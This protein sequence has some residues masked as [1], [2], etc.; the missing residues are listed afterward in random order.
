MNPIILKLVEWLLIKA[1]ASAG[2]G[3]DWKKLKRKVGK[4]VV[5]IVPGDVLDSSAKEVVNLLLDAV[6]EIVGGVKG[7][8]TPKH[9]KDAVMRA[10]EVVADHLGLDE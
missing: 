10:K 6:H 4:K 2:E 7:M 9:V 8:P 3:V 5:E 1:I